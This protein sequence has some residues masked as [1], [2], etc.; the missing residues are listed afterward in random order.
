MTF[1]DLYQLAEKLSSSQG[2]YGRLLERLK[3]LDKNKQAHITKEMQ[4]SNLKDEIDII[5]WLE[6]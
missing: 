2:F 4:K 6:S 1:D 5:L 3:E